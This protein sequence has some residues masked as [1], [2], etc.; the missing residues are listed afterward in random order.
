MDNPNSLAI[1]SL[2]PFPSVVTPTS[3]SGFVANQEY[4]QFQEVAIDT[5]TNHIYDIICSLIGKLQ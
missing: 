2:K 1:N 3:D 4:Y 5:A